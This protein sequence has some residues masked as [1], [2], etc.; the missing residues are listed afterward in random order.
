V[1]RG[2]KSNVWWFYF[3]KAGIEIDRDAEK[4]GRRQ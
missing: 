1:D 2:V 4:K 3:E